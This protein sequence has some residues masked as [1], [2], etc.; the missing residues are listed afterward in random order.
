[1]WV[2]PIAAL[3]LVTGLA[4]CPVVTLGLQAA[5]AGSAMPD[6]K[7]ADIAGKEFKSSQLKGSVV[8]LDVW[9]TWC[10]PCIDDIPIFNR[11]HEKYADRGLKVVGIA[12]QSGWAND[13]KPHV[14][15]LGIKY[16]VLVGNEEVTQQYVEVGFPITY[17]IAPDGKIVKKYMGSVP[18]QKIGKEMDLEREIDRLLQAR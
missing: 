14:T 8:V 1:M 7:L 9:A 3:L 5:R 15:K 13:I 6:F 11:L 12:V 17:L 2:N 18:D 10:E 4:F 16:L